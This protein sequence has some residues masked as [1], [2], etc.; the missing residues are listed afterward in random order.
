MHSNK[1]LIIIDF[2]ETLYKK[3]S[4]IA[5]CKFIYKKKPSQIWAVIPQIIGSVFYLL[6]LIDTKKYKE[7]FLLFLYGL[8][9]NEVSQFAKEFWDNTGMENFNSTITA[10][11]NRKEYRII[12]ISASPELYL[13]PILEVYQIELIGTRIGLERNRYKIIGENCKGSEKANR[14][15]E[16]LNTSEVQIAESYSDSL[17]DLPLFKLSKKGFLIDENGKANLLSI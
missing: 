16:Y 14:L 2:D 15:R 13:K 6:K 9:E 4:L 8:K 1:E 10:L 17:S 5:F 11:F 3:D 12:C 7:L